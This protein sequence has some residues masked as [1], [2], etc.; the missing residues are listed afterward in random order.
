MP[1][2]NGWSTPLILLENLTPLSEIYSTAGF[3]PPIIL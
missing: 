2:K 3:T 1:W